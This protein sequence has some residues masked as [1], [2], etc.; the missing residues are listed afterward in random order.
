MTLAAGARRA[1]LGRTRLQVLVTRALCR[2]DP[3]QVVAGALAGGAG[4]IQIR[5]PGATDRE[6]LAWLQAVRAATRQ[7]A[8]LLVVN[9]RPDLALLCEADGVHVGQSDL[10]PADVRRLVGPGLLVGHSTHSLEQVLAASRE[11]L[12]YLGLGPLRDTG[13]KRLAGRGPGLLAAQGRTD[14]PV[15]GI[16]GLTAGTLP[17]F[18]E[19]GLRRAAVSAAVCAAEDPEAATRALLRALPEL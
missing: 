13:T 6:L 14:L 8:A 10:A 2:R 17:A 5:E 16:G 11:P 12:D 18:V 3:L 19:A 1:A 4:L 15:F 7:V 9:D